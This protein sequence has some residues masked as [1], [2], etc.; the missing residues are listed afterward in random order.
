MRLCGGKV[1]QRFEQ[2]RFALRV[3]AQQQQRPRRKIGGEPRVK[4]KIGKR[5][6]TDAHSLTTAPFAQRAE[7]LKH[8]AALAHSAVNP[9][10]HHPVMQ[11]R[12][13]HVFHALLLKRF[14]QRR[15]ASGFAVNKEQ[16]FE[17]RPK[18]QRPLH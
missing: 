17:L 18:R 8:S 5:E 4:P 7:F 16:A 11:I 9:L 14:G 1:I 10:Q 15:R 13:N 3:C 12:G 2:T 6:M